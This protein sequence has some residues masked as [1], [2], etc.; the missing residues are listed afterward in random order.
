MWHCPVLS[1]KHAHLPQSCRPAFM[2][3]LPSACFLVTF[4]QNNRLVQ[5]RRAFRRRKPLQTNNESN[6]TYQPTCSINI[7]NHRLIHDRRA[8]RQ[9]KPRQ[10]KQ[11]LLPYWLTCSFTI[12]NGR[13]VTKLLII[14]TWDAWPFSEDPLTYNTHNQASSACNNGRRGRHWWHSSHIAVSPTSPMWTLLTYNAHNQSLPPATPAA[15]ASTGGTAS[16]SP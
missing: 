10:I 15:A 5:I 16:A 2:A 9:R 3:A 6:E 7:N 4:V 12:W 1:R 14:S 11:K 13:D 8:F